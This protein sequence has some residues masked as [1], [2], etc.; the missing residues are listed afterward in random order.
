[1]RGVQ[2]AEVAQFV[3]A[4]VMERNQRLVPEYGVARPAQVGQFGLAAQPLPMQKRAGGS[5]P[6]GTVFHD[7]ARGAAGKGVGERVPIAGNY[8]P[9][10]RGADTTARQGELVNGSG[11]LTRGL[12]TGRGPRVLQ[13]GV[14]AK[15]PE[16]E[17]AG[18]G[19]GNG[20]FVFQPV[21]RG[22]NLHRVNHIELA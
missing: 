14:Q 6:G 9:Q 2:A 11:W 12:E 15:E 21:E 3:E 13:V 16:Q 5:E 4:E 17:Q 10:L 18:T 22:I 20:Q 7:M 1:M 8:L 19:S